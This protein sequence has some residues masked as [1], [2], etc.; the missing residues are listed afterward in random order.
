MLSFVNSLATS[1]DRFRRPQTVKRKE[2][3]GALT[4]RK[5]PPYYWLLEAGG[6]GASVRSTLCFRKPY[7]P[8]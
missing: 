6:T 8:Q 5:N 3:V 4:G 2:V 7:R 1:A